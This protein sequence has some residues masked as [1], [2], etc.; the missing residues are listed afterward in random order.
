MT[1]DHRKLQLD[2][3]V[4]RD[5][6]LDLRSPSDAR[7]ARPPRRKDVDLDFAA[8]RSEVANEVDEERFGDRR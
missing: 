8:P 4:V 5:D 6:T 1:V 7:A 3:E 2:R